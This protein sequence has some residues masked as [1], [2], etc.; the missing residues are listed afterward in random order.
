LAGDHIFPFLNLFA[1][2]SGPNNNPRRGILLSLTIAG[3][4]IGLG[5]LDLIAR[6]VT[7]FFLISY[8]LLNYATYF[9]GPLKKSIVPATLQMVSSKSQPCR[10]PGLPWRNDGH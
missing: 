6:I 7:M 8:G 2:G 9:G 1:K 3:L 4:T 10:I 5:Q